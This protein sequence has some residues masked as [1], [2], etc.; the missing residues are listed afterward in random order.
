LGEG[1]LIQGARLAIDA[2]TA[3]AANLWIRNGITS[4]FSAPKAD[5]VILNLSGF[6]VMP[7]LINSHDHLEL[8]LFPKLGEGVYP[9]ASA[10]AKD[11]YRP[12]ESPVKQHLAV[13]KALR[14]AWGAVKN[15]LSGVTTVAHHNSMHPVLLDD[16]L[17]VRVVRHY[18]WA[19]SVAF[20]EDWLFRFRETP[21]GNA[22]FIHAAEGTD[23]EA[24]K[25]IHILHRAGALGRAT[26]L[27]HGV[28]IGPEE[29]SL[30]ERQGSSLVWCPSSNCFTLGRTVERCVLESRIPVALGTDSAMTGNGDLLDE[31]R[32]A[33]RFMPAE[34]LFEMVTTEAARILKLPAGFGVLREHGP[35][36]L[37]VMRDQGMTPA[38]TLIIGKPELVIVCGRIV[39]VSLDLIA[40]CMHALSAPLHEIEVEG[41]GRYF[42]DYDVANLFLKTKRVLDAELR[43]AGKAVAA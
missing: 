15:V 16:S 8:N 2:S 39:L 19:H 5:R 13:P 31:L 32:F 6:M 10:W 28:A 4:F 18:R 24:R 36:D 3:I 29:F 38:E 21:P 12:N 42:L 41:R 25:E 17:P 22:F 43:L 40:H 37:L 20:S 14:L 9:N 27:V 7:G 35:A 1:V 33:R 23:E 11:I 26:V 34:R 30:V